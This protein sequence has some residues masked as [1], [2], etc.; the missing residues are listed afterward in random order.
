MQNAIGRLQLSWPF[1]AILLATALLPAG[2]PPLAVAAE[3]GRPPNVVII[4]TDDQGTLDAN[5]CGSKDLITPHMDRLAEQGVR[6]TQMYAPSAICSASRAGLMTGRLPPR[7]GVPGNCSSSQGQPGMPT[8]EV[9]IAEMLKAAGY[10]TGHVGKWHLGYTPETMPGGQGFDDTFGHM[11]G[12]IDNY[13]HFFYWVGP[14]RH[15]LWRNGEEIWEDGRFFPDMMAEE[16][17]RFIE[18]NKDRPFFVYWANNV[19]HYPLQGTEA[20]RQKY[21]HLPSPRNMY[22]AFVSTLDERIGRVVSKIDELGL[23]EKTLIIFQSDHGHS[24]EERTFGGGGNAGP[25]RGAKACLFEGG[26]RVP[27]IVSMPGTIPQG[28][29]RDQMAVGCDW[30]PTIA[31][32]CG[33][34]LPK[35]K[36]DGKSLRSVILSAEAPSPHDVFYWQL[37]SGPNAQ[38]V[39][40]QGAWKLLGNPRDTSNKAPL[41]PADNPFLCN[42]AE[43]ITEMKNLAAEHP[44]VV[45][46]LQQVRKK[47]AAEIEGKR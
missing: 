29:L 41:T 1:L 8:E 27:A 33:A 13:S 43:D 36:L 26:L 3:T 15:D 5:C 32:F 14:N 42:L 12:C 4:Y 34:K 35:R 2:F 17:E 20:W 22:A 19:P 47:Y 24:T 38:W 46:Q 11:G 39:V 23:R 21:T 40:R 25:Y 45:E 6:F 44:E 7:A 30:L 9:T 28:Q 37:G 31:E 10:A 16:C 18:K